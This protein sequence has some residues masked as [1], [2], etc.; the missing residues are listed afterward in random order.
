M[1]KL[2]LCMIVKNEEDVLNRCL[3]C[4]KNFVDEIIIVDTGST[5]NTKKLASKFT[6]KIYDFEWCDDFSKARNFSFSKAT[7]DYIIWLDAD[8]VVPETEQAKFIALKQ[9]LSVPNA[10]DAV[11]C[12]YVASVNEKNEPQFYYFRERIVKNE[13][14]FFWCDPI[15]EYINLQGNVISR[16][17]KVFHEKVHPTPAKRNLKIYQNLEKSKVKF[18]PRALYYYGRELHYNRFYKKSNKILSQFLTTNGWVENKIDACSIMSQNYLFLGEIE[19]A[20]KALFSSLIYEQPRAKIACEI[21]NIFAQNQDYKTAKFWYKIALNS[22]PNYQG[23]IEEK[24]SNFIPA[25]G[26]CE[27]CFYLGE[28]KASKHYHEISK[29]YN[30]TAPEVIFNENFFKNLKI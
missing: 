7:G 24:Y 1:I 20:K 13:P 3:T 10:P 12:K 5:D 19:Q 27:C 9:E 22:P 26:L 25:L 11:M 6:D 4:A 17:I 29:K 30:S 14:C 8:D 18:S 23:F 15:H 2:S 21:A 28:I 16:D